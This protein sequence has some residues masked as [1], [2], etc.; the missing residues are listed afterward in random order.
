MLPRT[1]GGVALAALLLLAVLGRWLPHPPNF[2][3]LGAIALYL[4]AYH[5]GAGALLVTLLAL[6]FS[7]LLLGFYHPVTMAAVYLGTLV[8][9]PCAWLLRRSRAAWRFPAVVLGASGLFFL[10]SNSGVWLSGEL[11]PRTAAGYGRC[12]LAALPFYAPTL[13]A[14]ACYTPLLFG[15]RSILARRAARA[16]GG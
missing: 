1:P 8:G 12:L 6:L 2:T 4:G 10:V 16:S 11:Y 13:A 5:R 15:A 9:I 7:D 3:P 14:Y